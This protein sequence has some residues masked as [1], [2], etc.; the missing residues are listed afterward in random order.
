MSQRLN[1]P[2]SYWSSKGSV[3]LDENTRAS[4]KEKDTL[5][6]KW[7]KANLENE[8]AAERL[9]YVRVRNKAKSLVRTAKRA[10]EKQIADRAKNV[11]GLHEKETENRHRS[12]SAVERC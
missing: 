5:H 1:H 4:L 6:R 11:L 2:T 3:P 8:K 10:Y 12:F 7:L 9:R